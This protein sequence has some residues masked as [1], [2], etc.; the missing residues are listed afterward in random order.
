MVDQDRQ[1]KKKLEFE[2]D[3]L[4]CSGWSDG[5][6]RDLYRWNCGRQDNLERAVDFGHEKGKD[7]KGAKNIKAQRDNTH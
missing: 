2:K 7:Y 6:L 3:G 1:E 4:R 5:V